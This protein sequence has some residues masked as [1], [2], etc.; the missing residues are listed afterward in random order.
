MSDTVPKEMYALQSRTREFAEEIRHYERDLLKTLHEKNEMIQRMHADFMETLDRLQ[1]EQ[2]NFLDLFKAQATARI[3]KENI[4]FWFEAVTQSIPHIQRILQQKSHYSGKHKE[5]QS[6]I[7]KHLLEKLDYL[8][9]H[10][11]HELE[12]GQW[13]E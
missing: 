8:L 1:Y 7:L 5:D 4:H 13:D 11:K 2:Q 10:I 3:S 9:K 12:S 6:L